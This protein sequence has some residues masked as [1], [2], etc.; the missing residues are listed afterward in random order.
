MTRQD[1]ASTQAVTG[2]SIA[3]ALTLLALAVVQGLLAVA[4]IRALVRAC[5]N[6]ADHGACPRAA[7]IVSLRGRDPYLQECL[8]SLLRQDYPDYRLHLVVDSRQDPAWEAAQS[9]AERHGAERV[10]VEVL[11]ERLDTCSLKCSAVAQ[12][13]GRLDRSV[14]V[15]A[16]ADADTAPHRWWLRELAAPLADPRVG[17]ATG[18]RWYMPQTGSWG[19]LVRYLWN[20]AAIVQMYW[21]EV[22]WGG[23]LAIKSRV[24]D[25]L[26]LLDRWRH[27]LCEDTMLY[28]QLGRHGLRVQFV[29]SL[30]MV[31][32]EDCGLGACL[33]WIRRQLLTMRLYHPR[34]P[35][36]LLHGLGTTLTLA[37]AVIVTAVAAWR[38]DWSAVAWCAGGV[39]LYE[40]IM[41]GLL[42]RMEMA[43]RRIVRSGG[44]PTGWLTTKTIL[45]LAPAIALTQA[46]YVLALLGAQFAR[47]ASWR[48]VCYQ[49]DGPWRIRRLDDPPY[50]GPS[51][52]AVD[53]H[54]L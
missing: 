46:V 54:S 31:N 27:A 28:R 49:I 35:L 24:I 45:R 33:V 53:G 14:E 34:W 11:E 1:A 50:D 47:R 19:A 29:P 43:V 16:L 40:A 10:H 22:A 48:G 13:I 7:V 44:G 30:M 3:I 26:N 25:E 9:L 6:P 36:V 20:A 37:A 32:R 52:R 41:V 8:E 12:A 15:V 5:W 4:L 21:Y 2:L 39:A 38:R 42:A 17:A 51:D 18:N 23:T